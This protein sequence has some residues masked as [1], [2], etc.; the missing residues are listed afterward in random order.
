MT[1]EQYWMLLVK[2][3]KLILFCLLL[4]GLVAYIVSRVIT[5]SYQSSVLV[6]I[7]VHSATTQA[8]Y[9]SLLASDQLVQTEAQLAVSD[10]VLREVALRYPGMTAESLAKKVTAQP[11]LNTQLFQISVVDASPSRAADLA[12]NIAATLIRQ[13]Q[14][15]IEQS[16]SESQQQLVQDLASTQQ[17]IDTIVTQIAA[18][19]G[20]TGNKVQLAILQVKLNG[21]QQHFSQGENALAQLELAQAQIGNILHIAQAAVPSIEPVYPNVFL[22]TGVG[23]VAGLFLGLLLAIVYERL[24]TRV[25]TV[26]G[27]TRLLGCTNLATIWRSNNSSKQAEIVNPT[28]RDANVESYRILRTNIGFASVNRPLHSIMVTSSVPREGKS[29]IAANLA[30]FMAKAGKSTLL[31]DADLRRPT[32]HKNFVV[33]TKKGLSNAIL[34]VSISSDRASAN[35]SLDDFIHEV[36]IPNLRVMPFGILPPNPSELLDSKAMQFVLKAIEGGGFE[37]VIFDTPPLLGLS[38]ASILASKVDGTIVV[39]DM[40][41]ARKESLRHVKDMLDHASAHVIGCVV[42][43]QRLNRKDTA[44]AYYHDASEEDDEWKQNSKSVDAGAV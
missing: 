23:L 33:P 35:F 5:P 13:Q 30:I 31:V 34:A 11:K 38:D 6:Q 2:Q 28:G 25:R 3:W 1:L 9:N 20:Q 29:V 41:L 36:S 39:V 7:T 27:I 22:N 37:V 8:D 15:A 14:Q 16:N 43:K 18:L 17:Q 19:Q 42:N 26:E 24:D 40:T 12:N 4:T 21:F 44:Y 32:Q 10:P